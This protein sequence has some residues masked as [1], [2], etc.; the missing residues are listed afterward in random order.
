MSDTL[1]RALG[2]TAPTTLDRAA[3]TVEVVALSG[4]A[5]AVR[6]APAPDGTRSAWVEELAAGGSDL[7]RFIAAPVLKDHIN[8]TDSAVGTIAD[9]RIEGDRIV[10]T[11]R[12]DGTPGA[13]ILMGQIEAGSVRGVSLGYRVTKWQPAGTRNGLPVFQ[14]VAWSAHEA[15]F[16]PCPVDA[17][18]VVRSHEGNMTTITTAAP[19]DTPAHIITTPGDAMNRAAINGEI[20]SIGRTAGMTQDWIDAQL[21]AGATPD[22]ARAAAFAEIGRRGGGPIQT[23]TSIQVGTDHTDPTAIRRAMSDALAAKLAPNLCKPE[24]RAAEFMSYRALGMVGALAS[25]R[26]E[27]INPYDTEGLLT[28]A[29]GAHSSGDFPELL[30][31][32]ANKILLAQYQLVPPTYRAWAARKSFNDF[33]EHSFLR[34][35]DMPRHSE[36]Q[37]AGGVK[38]GTFSENKETLKAKE[39]VSGIAIGRRMLVNDDLG[40]LSDFASGFASAAAADENQLA[41]SVINGNGAVLKSDGKTLFHTDHFNLASAGG[42]DIATVAAARTAMSRQTS[43]DGRVMN[44]KGSILVIGPE[45]YLAARK[46]V[47]SVTPT[48]TSDVNPFSGAFTIVEDAELNGNEW[49]IFADPNMCPTVVFGYVT[50]DGPM[51]L[52]ERDFD[53]QGVKIRSSFDFAVGPI[54]YR[55]AYRNPGA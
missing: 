34:R 20:R 26:G 36:M 11:V 40:A 21:D 15:S 19:T 24:G 42:I 53:T 35:G 6:P 41:Y 18:A 7:S 2:G 52:T 31:A 29:V 30:A 13:E 9:A 38:Y 37:E 5:P 54:D 3:R 55:G 50:G 45:N 23:H 46:L 25:A 47:T 10:A 8:R 44:L 1:T 17:G 49:Y 22:Q 48:T 33:K 16:T 32:T 43:L 28:R 51:I 12:F 27:R 39:Y 4:L 14:A